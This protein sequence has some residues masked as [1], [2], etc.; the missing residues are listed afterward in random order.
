[1]EQEKNLYHQ[2]YSRGY[3]AGYQQAL[4]DYDL[5]PKDSQIPVEIQTLPLDHL[6]LSKRA[7]NCLHAAGC[8]CMDDVCKLDAARI[9]RM[10]NLGTK[11]AAEIAAVII[12]YGIHHTAWS[13]FVDGI[14]I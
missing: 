9:L 4:A 5:I 8:H 3:Q 1:M 12:E 13:Q 2:G 11:T 6:G 14:R 10:R 7:V